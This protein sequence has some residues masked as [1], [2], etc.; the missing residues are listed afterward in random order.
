MDDGYAR[1]FAQA[2][3]GVPSHMELDTQD[4]VTP[5]TLCWQP[6]AELLS[7]ST[8]IYASASY[9]PGGPVVKASPHLT[10]AMGRNT[11]LH[12]TANSTAAACV[13]LFRKE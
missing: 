5:F 11:V 7:L 12:V 2:V 8:D 4:P 6:T 10:V 13:T 1:P 9:Y 3:A